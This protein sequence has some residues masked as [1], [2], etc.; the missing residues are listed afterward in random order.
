MNCTNGTNRPGNTPPRSYF[1]DDKKQ[2]IPCVPDWERKTNIH[3][4]GVHDGEGEHCCSIVVEGLAVGMVLDMG[5]LCTLVHQDLVPPQKVNA[6][7]KLQVQCA[8]GNISEYPTVQLEISIN[9]TIFKI[10]TGRSFTN[11]FKTC[12]LGM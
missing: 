2:D 11:P 8:H 5:A 10:R 3:H 7:Q 9:G 4:L 6:N 1:V 12:S